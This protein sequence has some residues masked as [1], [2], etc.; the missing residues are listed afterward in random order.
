MWNVFNTPF[1]GFVRADF[2]AYSQDKW[3]SNLHTRARMGVRDKLTAIGRTVDTALK[4]AGVSL[5]HEAND[6]RPSVFNAKKVDAQWIFFTRTEDDKRTLATI[7]DKRTSLAESVSD[8]AHHKRHVMLG[9]KVHV[10]GA[11]VMLGLHR[12]AWVD[13]RN[14]TKK[15]EDNWARETFSDLLQATLPTLAGQLHLVGPSQVLPFPSVT[16]SA[17]YQEL[18]ALTEARGDWVIWGR[19]FPPDS[20]EVAEKGFADLLSQTILALVPLYQW[21]AWSNENDFMGLKEEIDEKKALAKRDGVVLKA[22]DE[23]VVNSGLFSGKVGTVQE[24]DKKGMV[25]VSVGKLVVQVKG[26]ALQHR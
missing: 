20:S 17:V 21:M 25:K 3:S 4:E 15:L 22:G 5:S 7:I 12:R 23:V 10:G 1:E 8:A 26:T 14:T 18:E 2:E 11:D 16:P 6:P 24:V 19:N 13:L 9:V